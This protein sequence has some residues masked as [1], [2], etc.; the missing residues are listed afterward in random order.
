MK[1]DPVRAD[2]YLRAGVCP[3]F[4][5]E[6][7][8]TCLIEAIAAHNVAMVEVLVT[9]KADVNF[10]NL[11]KYLPYDYALDMAEITADREILDYLRGRGALSIDEVLPERNARP[12]WLDHSADEEGEARLRAA[13]RKDKLAEEK[14]E[15][16]SSQTL[17]KIF[18]PQKWVGRLQAMKA[19]WQTVPKP[20]QRSFDMAAA[21]AKVRQCTLDTRGK[22][23]RPPSFG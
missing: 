18:D 20:L 19:L 21:V 8:R 4:F 15:T 5:T 13:V 2:E 6:N 17:E 3:D 12:E 22:K 11:N 10:G 7:G 16:F 23:P 14:V 9:R 1:N